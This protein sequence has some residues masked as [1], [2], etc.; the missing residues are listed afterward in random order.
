MAG[1]AP[2]RATTSVAAPAL[3]RASTSSPSCAVSSYCC[4]AKSIERAIDFLS[5][6]LRS[7]CRARRGGVRS[8]D[9]ECVSCRC[10]Q[11]PWA[12]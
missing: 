3:S 6:T 7:G 11:S 5:C 2:K 9:G 1:R 8:C 10:G 12:E 4:A